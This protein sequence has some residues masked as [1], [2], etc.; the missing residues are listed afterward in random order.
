MKKK[1][2]RSSRTIQMEQGDAYGTAF[3]TVSPSRA[4]GE[5][6]SKKGDLAEENQLGVVLMEIQLL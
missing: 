1:M 4:V 6:T 2:M 3:A 5:A